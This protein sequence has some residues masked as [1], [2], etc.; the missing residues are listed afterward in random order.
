MPCKLKHRLDPA[1]LAAVQCL[2]RITLEHPVSGKFLLH[3]AYHAL[4][5]EWLAAVDTTKWRFFVQ[6]LVV[7]P[8][9]AVEQ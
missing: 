3:L 8:M 2:Q 9:F 7:H 4:G 6:S 5:R 1:I